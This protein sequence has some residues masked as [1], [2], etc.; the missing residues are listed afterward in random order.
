MVNS[1]GASVSVRTTGLCTALHASVHRSYDNFPRV[2]PGA[3]R[4]G[5]AT[6][7]SDHL[8]DQRRPCHKDS[9][10]RNSGW[11]HSQN[12]LP[13]RASLLF[14]LQFRPELLDIIQA[15]Y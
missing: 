1:M 14:F 9:G 2:Y 11:L 3:C 12:I 5:P 8:P 10:G 15:R 6:G 13:L 4:C 7:D